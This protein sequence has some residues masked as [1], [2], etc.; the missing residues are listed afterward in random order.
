MFKGRTIRS[1]FKWLVGW[2]L[3][4]RASIF[5]G[6]YVGVEEVASA[7]LDCME[8]SFADEAA[9][10]LDVELPAGGVFGDCY[11]VIFSV[12]KSYYITVRVLVQLI[13]YRSVAGM[14]GAVRG[15]LGIK[16]VLNRRKGAGN[17]LS[18]C[19]R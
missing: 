2:L 3:V 17:R 4:S 10:G 6:D 8:S 13:S 11:C 12:H 1:P 5:V 18:T 9:D 19:L 15:V 7:D 16:K 14:R